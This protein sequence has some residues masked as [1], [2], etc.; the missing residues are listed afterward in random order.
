MSRITLCFGKTPRH[1]DRVDATLTVGS[2]GDL[3][4]VD[5]GGVSAYI[6]ETGIAVC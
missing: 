1:A 6:L 4:L 5:A 2:D 3:V